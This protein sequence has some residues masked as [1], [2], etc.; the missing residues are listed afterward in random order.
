M[1]ISLSLHKFPI[2][3]KASKYFPLLKS[4]N[5][6]KYYM[7]DICQHLARNCMLN[8]VWFTNINVTLRV[9]GQEQRQIDN[10]QML[11]KEIGWT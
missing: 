4:R 2:H 5:N 7:K 11:A 1:T 9:L 10:F 6:F 3:I 8:N